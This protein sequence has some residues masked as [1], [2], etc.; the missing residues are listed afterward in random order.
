MQL[1]PGG[2]EPSDSTYGPLYNYY[3][4]GMPISR[5]L[6][7]WLVLDD[8]LVELDKNMVDCGMKLNCT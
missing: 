8:G 2:Y 5:F 3:M 1:I 7:V 4:E 6:P